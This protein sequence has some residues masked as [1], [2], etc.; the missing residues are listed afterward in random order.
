M[1]K[2]LVPSLLGFSLLAG[3]GADDELQGVSSSGNNPNSGIVASE[4]FSITADK[5]VTDAIDNTGLFTVTEVVFTA[6]VGDRNDRVLTDSHTVFF[7]TEFGLIEPSCT[8]S[9]GSGTCTVTWIIT[10]RPGVTGPGADGFVGVT[11]YTLGEESFVD[12]VL[13]N[14]LYDDGETFDDVPEPF[15]DTN[16]NDVYDVGVDIIIDVPNPADPAGNN[17]THDPSDTE[18]NGTACSGPNNCSAS[19]SVYISD[20]VTLDIVQN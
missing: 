3:C 6:R 2:L 10:K 16:D 8:T 17:V 7:R 5:T 13:A 18:F 9:D 19:R 12:T 20:M 1:N 4:H 11:G 14:N 15:V